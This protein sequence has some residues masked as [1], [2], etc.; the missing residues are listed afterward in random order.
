M[1][2]DHPLRLI[3][4]EGYPKDDLGFLQRTHPLRGQ[5]FGQLVYMADSIMQPMLKPGFG[6]HSHENVEVVSYV[7]DGELT[8][9]DNAGH[10]GT[11]G[12]GS[13]QRITAG[14]GIAHDE[15]NQTA[16]PLRMFQIW[17]APTRFDVAPDSAVVDTMS[18]AQTHR[19]T[20]VLNPEGH[21]DAATINADATLS[22]GRFDDG[23]DIDLNVGANRAVLLYVV[24]GLVKVAGETL[25][26]RDQLRLSEPTELV[27][28]SGPATTLLLIDS[29]A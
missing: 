16:H 5:P 15:S 17:F 20:T 10:S 29:A 11:V 9:R 2:A 3:R 27:G 1:A 8:H 14:T 12:A 23:D 28:R 18:V 22:V 26:A 4:H 25:R 24:D 13:F 19:F 6:M 7:H 21:G